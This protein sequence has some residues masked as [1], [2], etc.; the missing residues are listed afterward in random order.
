[1]IANEHLTHVLPLRVAHD[2]TIDMWRVYTL[3]NF[4]V[5]PRLLKGTSPPKVEHWGPFEREE[6]AREL[7]LMLT[8]HIESKWPK[9]KGGKRAKRR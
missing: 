6:D 9:P 7:A 3:G 5:G 1:M 8:K 4:K 2:Y